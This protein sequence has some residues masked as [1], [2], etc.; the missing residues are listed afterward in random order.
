MDT[1]ESVGVGLPTF[2]LRN[3]KPVTS[4]I[5]KV[6][7]GCTEVVTRHRILPCNRMQDWYY[8]LS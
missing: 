7:P 8:I 4:P 3:R 5:T 2:S 6:K 1:T